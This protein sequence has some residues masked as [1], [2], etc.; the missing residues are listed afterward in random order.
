MLHSSTDYRASL[1]DGGSSPWDVKGAGNNGSGGSDCSLHDTC[2]AY[3]CGVQFLHLCGVVQ[4]YSIRLLIP[5]RDS[6]M[7]IW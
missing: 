5:H 7:Q 2:T 4:S 1:E 3:K 6:S